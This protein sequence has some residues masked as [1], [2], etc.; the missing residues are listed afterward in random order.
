MGEVIADVR[1]KVR[2]SLVLPEGYTVDYERTARSSYGKGA[3]RA[4]AGGEDHMYV[5][6]FSP[7]DIR[8][9]GKE[10]EHLWKR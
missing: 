2:T 1:E 9:T 8:W 6:H 10:M 3:E 4:E 7:D 5:Y